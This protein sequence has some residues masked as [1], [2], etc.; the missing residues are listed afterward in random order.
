MIAVLDTSYEELRA[1]QRRA[2]EAERIASRARRD[3]DRAAEA[4]HEAGVPIAEI[5]SQLGLT[6][7]AV[8]LRLSSRR[9]ASVL[10]DP[11]HTRQDETTK[12]DDTWS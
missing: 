9:R 3:R 2:E 8:S 12:G 6:A 1:A 7:A 4:L 10:T 11:Q 5:A